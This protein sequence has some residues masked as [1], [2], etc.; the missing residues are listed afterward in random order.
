MPTSSPASNTQTSSQGPTTPRARR[1]HASSQAPTTPRTYTSS[2]APRTPLAHAS[3][4]GP[5]TPIA[6]TSSQDAPR[7]LSPI[8]SA[9]ESTPSSSPI[10]SL[11]TERTFDV[12]LADAD[13]SGDV[14]YQHTRNLR[15]IKGTHSY[16]C[17][18]VQNAVSC[19]PRLDMHLQALGYDLDSKTAI[20]YACA[21]SP[22]MEVFVREMV[23]QGLP[24][25]EAKYMWILYTSSPPDNLW[26]ERHI[27]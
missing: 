6:H 9:P 27:M 11:L 19:G 24:I 23:K 14:V 26:A 18:N 20:A 17:I 15:G 1:T 10:L 8:P 4:Q 2:Q 22:V 3:S 16:P 21:T 12:A 25:L 5:N 13:L 7:S